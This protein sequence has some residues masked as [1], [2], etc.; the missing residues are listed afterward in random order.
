MFY[1]R[2][3][4]GE[5][6]LAF[7]DRQGGTSL[8]PFDGLNLGGHVGDDARAV[9]DNRS[10]MATHLGQPAPRLVLMEQVHGAQVAVV[11]DVPAVAPR[12]DAVV[13]T[14]PGLALAALVA[15]CTPIL[16]WDREGPAYGAVH[17]GRPGLV[18]GVVAAAVAALRDLGARDLVAVV[19]PSVCSRCYEV[20]ADLCAQVADQLPATRAVSWTGTPALDV[21]AGA[22]S[23]LTEQ[24]VSLHAWVSGCSREDARLFS[25]RR[26]GT[27]G[28]FGGVITRRAA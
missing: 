6:D 14:V 3:T 9:A 16:L 28:R 15:D 24:G 23:Q 2:D 19:G 18:V 8:A 5:V 22:V 20:P 27:T 4:V 7:T 26:S 11:H 13:S 17:C 10:L 25:H 1:W 21:A 12:A